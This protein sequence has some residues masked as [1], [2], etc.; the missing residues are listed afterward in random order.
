MIQSES[1]I[2]VSHVELYYKRKTREWLAVALNK[3]GIAIAGPDTFETMVEGFDRAAHLST[4]LCAD[5]YLFSHDIRGERR[6]KRVIPWRDLLRRNTI[7]QEPS[8]LS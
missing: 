6:V 2:P 3:K 7:P 5:V 8:L 1:V 4:T